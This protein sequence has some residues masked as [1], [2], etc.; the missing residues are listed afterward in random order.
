MKRVS[1]DQQSERLSLASDGHE[2]TGSHH[3]VTEADDEAGSFDGEG[4]WQ[5]SSYDT[6]GLSD[7]EIRKLIKK[8]VNPQLY[9]EMKAARKGKNKWVGPLL[10]NSFLG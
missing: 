6:T 1:V 2:D 3:T 5:S 9:A 4:N 8:G 7:A 10:G